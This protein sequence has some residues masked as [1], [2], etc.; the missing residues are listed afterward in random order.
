MGVSARLTGFPLTPSA[1]G[2]DTG[3]SVRLPAAY[4]GVVGLK[5]SYG[6]VSRYG[7]LSYADSLDTVGVL[8]GRVSDVERVFG[9]VSAPD[10]NDMTCADAARR[11]RIPPLK[12]LRG[13]KVGLPVQTH[14]DGAEQLDAALIDYLRAHGAEV[15]ALSMPSLRLA[16]PAYYVLSAAEAASNLARY[17]GGWYGP[18]DPDVPGESGLQRRRR[19]R[20]KGFGPEARKRILAGTYALTADAFRNSY[21]K[22]LHLRRQVQADF[23]HVFEAVDVLLHPTAVG[24]APR[25]DGLG[26]AGPGAEYLQDVLTV[27]ASLAG[28]PS[29]SVPSGER[30]GW[31]VGVSATGPWGAEGT[32]F[33]LGRAVEQWRRQ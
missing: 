21:L 23:E 25:L 22:A 13:L 5:P 33:E 19:V 18:S 8:A 10:A 9:V 26:D 2:T 11:E 17:G 27:P 4:C 24:P 32:L 3:G 12:G 7:V 1:L 14:V 6:L 30:G 16:L 31:P 15:R 20:T 28:L 29:L